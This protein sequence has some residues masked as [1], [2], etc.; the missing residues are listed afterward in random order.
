M[1]SSIKLPPVS[2]DCIF[3]DGGANSIITDQQ[4]QPPSSSSNLTTSSSPANAQSQSQSVQPPLAA[5]TSF[6]SILEA[7]SFDFEHEGTTLKLRIHDGV[8]RES[9]SII[10]SVWSGDK[11]LG[12]ISTAEPLHKATGLKVVCDCHKVAKAKACSCWMRFPQK[13]NPSE[14]ER[15][16]MLQALCG[17]L[18]DGEIVD[19]QEHEHL[20]E[21][22]RLAIGMNVRVKK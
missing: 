14:A 17:W 16:E 19:R 2:Q 18:G 1:L 15:T 3:G 13:S 11:R 10:A 4:H 21:T 9:T 5:L 22:L 20:S 6:A 7:P 12:T 8:N